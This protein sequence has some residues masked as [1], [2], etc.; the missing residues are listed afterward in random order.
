M[1]PISIHQC[2]LTDSATGKD[3]GQGGS[4]TAQADEENGSFRPSLI[5]RLSVFYRP[6][7]Q[8]SVQ[9]ASFRDDKPRSS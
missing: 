3:L 8:V 2:Q 1:N 7:A 6:L 9:G 4:D 5:E